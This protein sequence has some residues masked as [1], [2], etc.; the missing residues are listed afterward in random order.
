M[1]FVECA[2]QNKTPKTDGR[3]GLDVVRVIEAANISLHK[4][5]GDVQLSPR[6][7]TSSPGRLISST[8]V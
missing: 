4:G 3:N 7:Q 6:K 8:Q 2:L 1:N 5:L